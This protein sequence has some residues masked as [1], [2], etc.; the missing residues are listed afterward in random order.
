MDNEVVV[1]NRDK[2]LER[3]RKKYPDKKFED[4]D[5][6]Y[7]AISDDYDEYE[8]ELTGY[9]DREKT[10]S[11]M[12]AADP[13]SA[14]FLSD[15]YKGKS[16]WASYIKLFGPELK[17]SLDDPETAKQIAEAESEYVERVATSRALEE[18]YEAN[19]R[20]T[21]DNLQKFKEERG[22][23]DEQIDEIG[24]VLIGIVRDGVMGKFAPETLDMI[25]KAINHDDD[26]ATAA[27]EAEVAGRNARITENLRKSKKGDGTIPL[28]GKNGTHNP[29]PARQRT[30]FDE[31]R[32][33]K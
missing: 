29:M 26:V 5:E 31:A 32:D 7:G 11:E 16:P 28:D 13:R 3:M 33:A 8:Q 17:D 10:M 15:M 20:T 12:F 22:L 23:S 30:V 1:S 4:E 2:H 25:V 19:M 21:L 24:A 9:R 18:E 27:E 6:I 14:Q